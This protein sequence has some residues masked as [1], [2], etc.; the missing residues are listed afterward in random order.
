MHRDRSKYEGYRLTY[1]GYDYLALHT[2]V[3]RGTI[4]GIGRQIGVGKESDIYLAVDAEGR[5]VVAA[6]GDVTH[7]RPLDD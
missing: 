7:L 4:T 3:A 1:M 6:A 2:F 5:Q